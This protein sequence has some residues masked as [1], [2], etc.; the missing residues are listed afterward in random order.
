VARLYLSSASVGALGIGYKHSSLVATLGDSRLAR[1]YYSLSNNFGFSGYTSFTWAN[2]RT[3][4]RLK[5][6]YNGGV[7]GDCSDQMLARV[8]PA[9]ASGA[10]T[11]VVRIGVNDVNNSGVGYTTRNTVGPNQ[12]V[13]VTTSNVAL[14]CFQNIQWAVQQFLQNGGQKVILFLESGA[15]VFGTGQIAATIDLNQR[16]REFAE[17]TR[18]VLLHDAWT[19]MHNPAASTASTLRFKTGYAAEATGSGTHESNLGAYMGGK[20]LANLIT[21]NYAELPFLP[22]DVNEITSITLNNLLLNPL[23]MTT[24]GGTGSGSNGV[25]GTIPGSWTVDR[26]GGGGTQTV[27]VSTGAPADGSPGNECVLACTFAAAGDTIRLRQDPLPANWAIGDIVEGVACVVIDAG[28]TSLAGIQMDL[29]LNDGTTTNSITDLKPLDNN[30]IGFDG[31]TLYLK[32][33][34]FLVTAKGAGAFMTMRLYAIG[35]GAGT[36]TI[37]W[38]SVQVRKR[39]SI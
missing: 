19:L 12:G 25:T 38:R 34:P 14:I 36:A 39:F 8:A 10:G 21:A 9:I 23:F 18:G 37:R 35:S 4:H 20:V 15:E 30:P 17:V 1:V 3:G 31:C 33:P 22:S 6:I 28:A 11:L 2:A 16:I 13:A 7:S 27:A 32:T 29:Q 5:V 24:S 26:F